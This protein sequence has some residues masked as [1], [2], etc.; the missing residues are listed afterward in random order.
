[1]ETITQIIGWIDQCNMNNPYCDVTVIFLVI[2]GGHFARRNL[3]ELPLSLTYST[4]ITGT[5]FS[6]IY[7]LLLHLAGRPVDFVKAFVSY[8]IA[9]SCYD[10]IVKQVEGYVQKKNK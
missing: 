9:T 10:L 2:L 1:M 8:C 3:A 5:A 4:L 7:L 6:C